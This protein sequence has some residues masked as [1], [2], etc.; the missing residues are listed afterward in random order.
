MSWLLESL[1]ATRGLS[2]CG[3]QTYWDPPSPG[4]QTRILGIAAR[5]LLSFMEVLIHFWLCGVF[6]NCSRN[7]SGGV[8]PWTSAFSHYSL[9]AQWVVRQLPSPDAGGIS[10]DQGLDQRLRPCTGSYILN[11]WTTKEVPMMTF[12]LVGGG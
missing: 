1:V 8:V 10:R 11:P 2:R 4:N 6:I 3:R 5:I 9:Q 12:F 7:F